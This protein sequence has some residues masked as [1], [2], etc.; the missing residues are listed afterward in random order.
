M[1]TI[2]NS[3][4]WSQYMKSTSALHPSQIIGKSEDIVL[5][6]HATSS[7]SFGCGLTQVESRMNDETVSSTLQFCTCSNVHEE[8]NSSRIMTIA[9]DVNTLQVDLPVV[10]F[11]FDTENN[12]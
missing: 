10:T 11:V 7:L 9:A 12:I 3:Y 6:I 4:E 1:A 5:N 8:D 2:L